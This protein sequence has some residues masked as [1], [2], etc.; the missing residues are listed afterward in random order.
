MREFDEPRPRLAIHC[1][2]LRRTLEPGR[3]ESFVALCT[4]PIRE[5]KECV[6]PFLDDLGTSCGLW[7]ANPQSHLIPLPQP[8]RWQRRRRRE[9]FD[10]QRAWRDDSR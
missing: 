3:A 2:W 4:H 5:G 7:E 8:E 9:G 6:G 10:L 1:Q